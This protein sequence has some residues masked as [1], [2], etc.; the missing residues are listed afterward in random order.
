MPGRLQSLAFVLLLAITAATWWF[1]QRPPAPDP[2]AADG[3][4]RGLVDYY[5]TGLDM[6]RMSEAGQPAHRLR[7]D[8]V[9]QLTGAG[10]TELERPLLT[11]FRADGSPPWRIDAD[12]AEVSADGELIVL[13]GGVLVEREREGAGAP[14]RLETRELRYR[15]AREYAE[16]D[17]PV[18]LTSDSNRIDGVGMQAWLRPPSRVRLLSQVAGT[19]APR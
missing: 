12:T 15:P 13:R 1:A 19:Y 9:R 10:T 5:V 17:Q 3:R 6:T 18:R 8:L 2:D 14:M 4:S 11:V 7:A 16:T